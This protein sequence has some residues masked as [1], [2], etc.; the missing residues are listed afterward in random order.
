MVRS[1]GPL[2]RS[3]PKAEPFL[4]GLLPLEPPSIPSFLQPI[5]AFNPLIDVTGSPNFGRP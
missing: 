5:F 2:C 1:L 4:V 3:K